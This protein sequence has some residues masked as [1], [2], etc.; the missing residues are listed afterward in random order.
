MKKPV[1][2]RIFF[3]AGER[4]G[5]GNFSLRELVFPPCR[6]TNLFDARKKFQESVCDARYM[7]RVSKHLLFKSS[8]HESS[9]WP[10]DIAAVWVISHFGPLPNLALLYN[11]ARI[12]LLNKKGKK[13]YGR[14]KHT[15]IGRGLVGVRDVWKCS[16]EWKLCFCPPLVNKCL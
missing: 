13:I 10:Q 14:R 15:E 11:G 8:S 1:A 2:R 12:C 7:F 9:S 5:W 3:S 16:V 4:R 6:R